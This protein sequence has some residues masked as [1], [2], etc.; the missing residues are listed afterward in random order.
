MVRLVPMTP[1]EFDG[2]IG[3]LIRDYAADHVAAGRWT[4]DVAEA[5]ARTEI[6]R[7]VPAGVATPNHL[8]F[9]IIADAADAR[10][11]VAWVA[12]E[13]RGAFVYYIE[14]FEA[15]RRRGY[16]E[17]AMRQLEMIALER[18]AT[19]TLL[20][21]F[22]TNSAARKLYAKLGYEE[23]N[24]LMAKGLAPPPAPTG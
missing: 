24:V 8:L 22:G 2:F 9:Q 13:P 5:E 14:I 20:H 19:K 3:G 12:I 16:A 7:L 10:V 17:Q 1:A 21:V 15:H 18:G 11:G 4:P 23:T 6:E